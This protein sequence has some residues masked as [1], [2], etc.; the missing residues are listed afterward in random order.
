MSAVNTIRSFSQ[1]A[2]TLTALKGTVFR[3][4]MILVKDEFAPAKILV[5]VITLLERSDGEAKVLKVRA[6]PCAA[7]ANEGLPPPFHCYSAVDAMTGADGFSM[8]CLAN[9][10]ACLKRNCVACVKVRVPSQ[11]SR[12]SSMAC[13]CSK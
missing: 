11:S 8:G 2:P 12:Q 3:M 7:R 9:A 10:C 6:S 1:A 5:G 13:A 4:A